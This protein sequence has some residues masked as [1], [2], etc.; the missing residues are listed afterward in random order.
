M[1][2][3]QIIDRI[4]CLCGISSL[5]VTGEGYWQAIK[6]A[7]TKNSNPMYLLFS[8]DFHLTILTIKL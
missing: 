5:E 2:F 6:I 3:H 1:P 7:N 8:I 4:P